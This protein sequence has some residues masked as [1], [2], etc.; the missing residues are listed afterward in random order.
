[1]SFRMINPP[2]LFNSSP[3]GFSQVV[4]TTG[5]P[6][7][8]YMSGQVAWNA[9]RE[10]VGAGDLH[11]QVVQSLRNIEIA[12]GHANATL[13]NVVALRLYIRQDEIHDADA[14]TRGLVK[15]FGDRL[16]CATWI[17]IPCL[18]HEDFLVEI[19]PTIDMTIS[20]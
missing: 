4:V 16:P 15:V 7:S 14:V 11:Q 17:G 6:P 8:V 20:E 9:Q 13:R 3:A 1:M 2:E 10:I 18:A 19:E 12:L 5:N